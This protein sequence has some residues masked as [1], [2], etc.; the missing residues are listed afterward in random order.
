ML[1]S[2]TCRRWPTSTA[3]AR[4]ISWCGA[5]SNGTWFWLTSSSG[6]STSA[7]QALG[8]AA[9]GDIPMVR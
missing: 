7:R 4:W 1:G 5:S 9:A 2:A 8:L 3:T 6:F